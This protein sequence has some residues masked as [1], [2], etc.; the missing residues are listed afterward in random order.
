MESS[1]VVL[2]VSRR[3]GQHNDGAD[4]IATDR[5]GSDE[6]EEAHL[7]RGSFYVRRKS[8]RAKERLIPLGCE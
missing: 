5:V 6:G 3:D 4:R 2:F 8:E 7:E 1:R